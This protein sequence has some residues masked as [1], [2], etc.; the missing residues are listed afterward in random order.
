MEFGQNRNQVVF[1]NRARCRDCYRCIRVCPVEA[2]G[3]RDG[4]AYVDER[5][6]I[7]CGTCIR[8]C[9]QKAKSYRK[10]LAEAMELVSAGRAAVSLAPS[11]ACLFEDWQIRRLPSALRKLGFSYVAETASGAEW[12]AD[13]TAEYVRSCPNR[14]SITTACPAVVQYV[15]R[16]RPTLRDNL[17]PIISPMLAHARALKA[18]LGS[19][20]KIVFIGPCVA[21]KAE[22]Q[23]DTTRSVDVALTFEELFEWLE[24]AQITLAELEESAFDERPVKI[25]R[26]FPLE[27]GS[28]KTAA[29]PVEYCAAQTVTVSGFEPICDVLNSTET[30][31]DGCVLEPLFCSQGCINGP[32][33]GAETPLFERKRAVLNYL[34]DSDEG[35]QTQ[36]PADLEQTFDDESLGDE[37]ITEEQIRHVLE[38]TGKQNPEDQLNCGAC[39]YTTCRRQAIAVLRQM[40]EPEMCVS[41]V[42]R[43]A[44]RRTDRIIE[45]SPNGIVTLDEHLT[46]LHMNSSFKRLFMCTDAVCGKPVSYLMDPEPFQKVAAGRQDLFEATIHH[47]KYSLFCHEIIYALRP[48]G[49]VIGIFV[50]LTRAVKN[51]RKYD[52][53]KA[54]TVQ[55]AHNLLRHQVEMAGKIAEYLGQSTAESEKLLVNLMQIAQDMSVQDKQE[56]AGWL[57]DIYTSK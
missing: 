17:V 56:S 1:T 43:M 18:K 57:K 23:A 42:R 54:Q 21:K 40:A 30:I 11:F 10:D 29:I 37:T 35:V 38:K 32:V 16:Y 15:L 3:I 39:G 7:S 51:K 49:Q 9:P 19:E 2:I 34:V 20:T 6:C 44:E 22:V 27:G 52:Q 24:L 41:Y 14:L 8:E 25:A 55:Q 4:Q 46:I 33:I 47:D 28:L 36:S 13:Q 48:E 26:L 12:V 50:N 5:R 31:K 53:L 45:T